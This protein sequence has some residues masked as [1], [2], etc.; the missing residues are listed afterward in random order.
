[1]LLSDVRV[2][3]AASMAEAV[4]VPTSNTAP[5]IMSGRLMGEAVVSAAGRSVDVCVPVGRIADVVVVVDAGAGV[6]AAGT[7]VAGAVVEGGVCIVVVVDGGGAE[8]GVVCCANALP[9]VKN[10]AA[11][12]TA[13]AI[14]DCVGLRIAVS[15]GV[16]AFVAGTQ[17]NG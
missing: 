12:P 9:T 13:P 4:Y 10:D 1:M 15:F 8:G 14:T 6:V 11:M 2:L 17:L 16:P 3:A 7:V 5:V